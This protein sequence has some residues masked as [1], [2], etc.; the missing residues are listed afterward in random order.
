MEYEALIFNTAWRAYKTPK[1]GSKNCT[2]C[3]TCSELF[4][5]HAQQHKDD[6]WRGVC[7]SM[8]AEFKSLVVW[9]L[10][11]SQAAE[12]QSANSMCLF[13]LWVDMSLAMVFS[14]QSFHNIG[15]RFF[16]LD[17]VVRAFGPA[18]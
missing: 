2:M 1:A 10:A 6:M 14:I 11:V 3:L 18:K 7:Q 13:R 12:T 8:A 5:R 17:L 15:I 9:M 16:V 4:R